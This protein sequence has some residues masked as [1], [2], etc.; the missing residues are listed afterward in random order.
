MCS[1]GS[2]L[3]YSCFLI[4]NLILGLEGECSSG[5]PPPQKKHFKDSCTGGW[6]GWHWI[7]LK[8]TQNWSKVV[9][10]ARWLFLLDPSLII[11]LACQSLILLRFDW[12]DP[13]MWR[14]TNQC[15]GSVLSLAMFEEKAHCSFEKLRSQAPPY[16]SKDNR[17]LNTGLHEQLLS[18]VNRHILTKLSCCFVSAVNI[19]GYSGV[20][21]AKILP[22]KWADRL[23]FKTPF[24]IHNR[25]CCCCCCPAEQEAVA[26]FLSDAS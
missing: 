16:R 25:W 13:G 9:N 18:L 24:L 22:E 12:C 3:H 26:H 8:S 5:L 6:F 7:T 17:V 23:S 14:F 1:F 15:L 4:F 10:S 20:E 21:E 11:A 19:W 2:L